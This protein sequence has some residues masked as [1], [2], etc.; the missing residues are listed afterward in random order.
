MDAEQRWPGLQ[1]KDAPDF[2]EAFWRVERAG[3]ILMTLTLVGVSLGLT[4][5]GVFARTE[6][7]SAD[8]SL[9]IEHLRLTRRDVA[10]SL[11]LRVATRASAADVALWL[12]PSWMDENSIQQISPVPRE[13][14]TEDGRLTLR[15]A[16]PPGG[17]LLT[18]RVQATAERVGWRAHEA[19]IVG[20][21]QVGFAQWVHP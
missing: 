4:G 11:D 3:W 15:F 6:K 16:A 19:G 9:S 7:Q 12:S 14:V 21:A 20:G 17:G 1:I 5:S 2:Q 18:V 10:Q 8:G 13:S